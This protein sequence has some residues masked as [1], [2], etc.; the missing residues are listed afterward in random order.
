[1]AAT[2]VAAQVL[3]CGVEGSGAYN[4]VKHVGFVT[5]VAGELDLNEKAP[6]AAMLR[7]ITEFTTLEARYSSL[8]GAAMSPNDSVSGAAGKRGASSTFN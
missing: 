7:D 2:A 5:T 8:S 6:V 1:M 3:L 4:A